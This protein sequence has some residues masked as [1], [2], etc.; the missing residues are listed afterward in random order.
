LYEEWFVHFR[1]PGHEEVSFKESE[2]G[3]IPEGW[4]VKG[5]YD[6]AEVTYGHPFKA[7]QFNDQGEGLGAVR[8]RDIRDGQVKTYTTEEGKPKHIIENGD[9]LVGMDGQFHM[10]KWAGGKAWLVQRVA[11][12]RPTQPMS[13]YL[14]FLTIERPIKHLE[15][16]IVGTTVAH[17]SAKDLKAMKVVVP[18]E[19]M[20]KMMADAL[21]PMY[22]LEMRLKRK[23]VNLRAQRD[24]L[25]PKLVSGEIDVSDMP[26]P[27]DK[28]VEAA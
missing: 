11:R 25:L 13:R 17:L 10:G 22:E 24:L 14:L 6:I 9:I 21:E 23:N 19:A 16:T 4:E 8:I 15:E 2:L 18:D 26:M 12:F 1:F 3:E 5:L 27:E 20:L 28:E 7:K